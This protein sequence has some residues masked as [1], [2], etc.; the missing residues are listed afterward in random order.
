MSPADDSDA[1][2]RREQLLAD[3]IAEAVLS[4]DGVIELHGGLFGEVGTYLPGRRVPGIRLGPGDG[5]E[6]HLVARW[7][8]P[9]PRIVD[10]VRRAVATVTEGEVQVTVE[11]VSVGAP[12]GGTTG[13]E[14]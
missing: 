10:A 7:G 4:V 13:R 1:G 3:R 9:I 6:I 14:L 2:G 11:D 12:A 5:V 8:V